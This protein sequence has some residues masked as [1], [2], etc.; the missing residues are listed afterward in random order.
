MWLPCHVISAVQYSLAGNRNL[1][2]ADWREKHM[3]FILMFYLITI[4]WSVASKAEPTIRNASLSFSFRTKRLARSVD[5]SNFFKVSGT[6]CYNFSIISPPFPPKPYSKL[7]FVLLW[8][9]WMAVQSCSVQK[10]LKKRAT[11]TCIISI[12]SRNK[13]TTGG[14]MNRKHCNN[15]NNSSHVTFKQQ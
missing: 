10:K 2:I 12:P 1:L 6:V 14:K 13:Q 4:F 5:V 8:N 15:V 9:I 3:K 7:I 11:A